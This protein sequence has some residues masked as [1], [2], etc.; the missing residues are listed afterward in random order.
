MREHS[1]S[2]TH[3]IQQRYRVA[4][5]GATY[6]HTYCG[7][8]ALPK[9]PTISLSV[10]KG[11]HT[12]HRG[13]VIEYRDNT[14]RTW[15]RQAFGNPSAAPWQRGDDNR[16]HD[17]KRRSGA[18][19]AAGWEGDEVSSGLGKQQAYHVVRQPLSWDV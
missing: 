10:E 12:R 15:R 6:T 2:K 19:T 9:S 16:G 3:D 1:G 7:E 4:D 14:V 17:R 11:M 5:V 8:G 13:D 18:D